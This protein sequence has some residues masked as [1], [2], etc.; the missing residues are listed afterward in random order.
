MPLKLNPFPFGCHILS[1]LKAPLRMNTFGLWADAKTTTTSQRKERLKL[2]GAIFKRGPSAPT[3]LRRRA[4]GR[5]RRRAAG[6]I[7]K[8][9]SSA[10]N[11]VGVIKEP[12]THI[13]DDLHLIWHMHRVVKQSPPSHRV[14]LADTSKNLRLI[15]NGR[16]MW[17]ILCYR[18]DH[19]FASVFCTVM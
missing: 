12:L 3:I 9:E 7:N 11:S 4:E 15:K 8:A 19:V 17:G 10:Q 6:R 16:W 5:S 14:T 18:E 1:C 13:C 2:A